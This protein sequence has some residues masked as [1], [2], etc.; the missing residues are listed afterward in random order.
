M[1]MSR[2]AFNTNKGKIRNRLHYFFSTTSTPVQIG[3][4][5]KTGFRLVTTMIFM[6]VFILLDF[7]IYLVFRTL[8]SGK[9]IFKILQYS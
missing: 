5:T 1:T 3:Y 4:D 6:A 7:M 9:Q 2:R 8:S